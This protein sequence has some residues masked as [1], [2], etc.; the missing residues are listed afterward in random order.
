MVDGPVAPDELAATMGRM[1]RLPLTPE[2]ARDIAALIQKTLEPARFRVQ[3][4]DRAAPALDSLDKRPVDLILLDL[5]LPDMDGLDVCRRLRGGPTASAAAIIVISAR[6]E[7]ADI[8]AGLELGADDYITKPF[9]PRVL[10]ARVRAV[11]RRRQEPES[12][13]AD[14][15][16]E[17]SGIVID[18]RR[19][20][21]RRGS[22][23]IQLTRSEFRILQLFCQKPGWV[24]TRNQ[25]VEAVHGEATPVTARSVDVLI[26]GLRQK[27]GADGA[28]VETVRGIGY[29]VK[30]SP[31][32][33]REDD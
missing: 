21:V 2:N 5:N 18:P 29:R 33:S 25:I 15:V 19:F 9:S 17:Y 13:A 32:D 27:L 22:E 23:L 3:A 28:L 7:E 14:G 4:F 8:V 6:D 20:E 24:F 26:V 1:P 10:M 30:E 11:L 31:G 16:I 12:K